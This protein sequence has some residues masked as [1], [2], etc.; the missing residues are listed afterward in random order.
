M[1]FDVKRYTE[2]DKIVI[3]IFE[4]SPSLMTSGKK[5]I[6]TVEIPLE[7]VV[8][9][10]QSPLQFRWCNILRGQDSAGTLSGELQVR[11]EWWSAEKLKGDRFAPS[12]SRSAWDSDNVDDLSELSPSSSR[13]SPTNMPGTS[14]SAPLESPSHDGMSSP[15]SKR[16]SRE[17]SSPASKRSPAP[18]RTEGELI[19]RGSR[20]KKFNKSRFLLLTPGKPLQIWGSKEDYNSNAKAKYSIPWELVAAVQVTYQERC[21]EIFVE[22]APVRFVF[23]VSP[24]SSVPLDEWISAIRAHREFAVDELANMR[25]NI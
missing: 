15:P 16:S 5:P 1:I 22:K 14:F 10:E 18:P 6:G 21:F 3:E 4:G 11:T 25:M 8:S 19:K 7:E 17:L 12:Y 2:T 24:K 23:M 20:L 9:H 13:A